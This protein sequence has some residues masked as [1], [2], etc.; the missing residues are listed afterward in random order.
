MH[1]GEVST[2]DQAHAS[3]P[4]GEALLLAQSDTFEPLLDRLAKVAEGR[5]DLRAEVAGELAGTWFA[6]PESHQGHELIA[7]GLLILARSIDRGAV[8]EAVRVSLER[9][10][11]SLQGY[12]AANRVP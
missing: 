3:A 11:G 5:D 7:A 10:K 8:A 2:A 6:R 9:S 1:T 4:T 12:P